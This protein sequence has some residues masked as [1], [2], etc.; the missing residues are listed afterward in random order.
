MEPTQEP[1]QTSKL[2]CYLRNKYWEKNKSIFYT[3][4]SIKNFYLAK[5]Q[6]LVWFQELAEIDK[7]V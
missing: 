2:I 1:A 4:E 6:L 3:L 5:H 7:R